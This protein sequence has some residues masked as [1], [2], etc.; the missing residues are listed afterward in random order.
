MTREV[1]EKMLMDVRNG[2]EALH[3]LGRRVDATIASLSIVLEDLGKHL[4]ELPPEDAS[5]SEAERLRAEADA[6]ECGYPRKSRKPFVYGDSQGWS[7]A[8]GFTYEE[9][10]PI[11]E[12]AASQR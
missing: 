6:H 1:A 11:F 9:K 5:V 10:L 12:S 2:I 7:C 4:L 3:D 8:C